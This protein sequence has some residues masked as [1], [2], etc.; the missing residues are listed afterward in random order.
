MYLP[1]KDTLLKG[2]ANYLFDDVYVIF[3]FLIF[4]IK[5]YIVGTYLNCVNIYHYTEV[6]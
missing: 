2:S 1:T 4:F 6:D 5:A 3:V